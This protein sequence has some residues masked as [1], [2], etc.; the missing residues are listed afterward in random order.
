MQPASIVLLVFLALAGG[1]RAQ[2]PAKPDAFSHRLWDEVLRAHVT[3]RGRV[4]YAAIRRD[5]RFRRYVESLAGVDPRRLPADGDRLAFW[6]NAYNAL[7]IDGILSHLP[8]DPRAWPDFKP[9]SIKVE[10]KSFW[11][12]TRFKVAGRSLTLDA[13]EHEK[14]RGDPALKDPRI[15]VALVC[16]ARGCPPLLN[17]A[18]RG[19][20]VADRLEDR[21]RAEV[22]D[23]E[24]TRLDPGARVIRLSRVFKWY[25][26][27]FTDP[28]FNP[29]ADSL[30]AF[31]ARYL[32]NRDV[33]RALAAG[34][35]KIE[36]YEYDWRLNGVGGKKG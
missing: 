31:I 32:K 12:G 36:F 7:T 4:D 8:D 21:M 25:G 9:T 5:P 28:K 33:A 13:I 16:A 24:R 20:T 22:N 2:A 10:G 17:R 6:I 19:S 14:I 29:H 11:R 1:V 23:P 30:G 26:K 3:D 34:K 35:W 15:H 27:D 18:Y